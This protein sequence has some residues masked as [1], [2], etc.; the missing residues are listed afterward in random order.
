MISLTPMTRD[1][2]RRR[3]RAHRPH[4]RETPASEQPPPRPN[5]LGAILDLGTMVYFQ[6]RG[7]SYGVPPLPWRE[8]EKLLDAWLELRSYGEHVDRD[9][10][11]G[12]YGALRR[13]SRL[14]WRNC[15]PPGRLPK[16]LKALG[17]KP[18]P[19]IQANETELAELAL[20]FLGRRTT[21][22]GSLRTTPAPRQT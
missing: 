15:R 16:L 1:E 3:W 20:F 2:M 6:F 9:N 10:L 21:R 5:N 4:P 7:R 18:N 8:G 11:D 14:L 13:I 22:T 17:L 19:F 12:Y